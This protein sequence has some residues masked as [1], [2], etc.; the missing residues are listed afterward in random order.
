MNV[1]LVM[2]TSLNGMIATKDGSE[3][4]LSDKNWAEFI[5]HVQESGCLIW[6]R[7]TYEAV[8]KWDPK[9]LES[10]SSLKKIVVSNSQMSLSGGFEI[11]SSP[12]N[13]LKKLGEYGLNNVV[14]SGG[15]TINY[16]FA[17]K[18]LINNVVF[19]VNPSILGDGI[20]V[21]TNS[22]LLIKLQL[23]KVE[24]IDEDIVVLNYKVIK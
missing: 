21:I 8:Q 3:D 22:D 13:A 12:E 19:F 4:F 5:K 15:A 20:S 7:K 6:G 16:E 18:G 17:K 1:T 9:Y 23:E 24:I 10:L 2:A 14:L 11:A